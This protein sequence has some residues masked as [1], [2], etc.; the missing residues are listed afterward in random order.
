MVAQITSDRQIVSTENFFSYFYVRKGHWA[1]DFLIWFRSFESKSIK[2]QNFWHFMFRCLIVDIEVRQYFQNKKYFT[3]RLFKGK[4][5]SINFVSCICN[6][7]VLTCLSKCIKCYEV[8]VLDVA[9][10]EFWS[11]EATLIVDIELRKCISK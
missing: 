10:K 5:Y 4:L 9:I 1:D 6:T 7:S 2:S 8:H 3:S 11:F